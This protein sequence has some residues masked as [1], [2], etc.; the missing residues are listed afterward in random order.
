M[1]DDEEIR[2]EADDDS[3]AEA[4]DRGDSFAG[5][6]GRQRID[7]AQHERIA[8]TEFQQR[9]VDDPLCDRF[10]V[11]GNVRQLGHG[12][13]IAAPPAFMM[14][15]PC[16]RPSDCFSLASPSPCSSPGGPLRC[17]RPF[18]RRSLEVTPSSF[19]WPESPKKRCAMTSTTFTAA[20]R[21]TPS[22]SSRR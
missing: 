18:Q 12:G 4:A 6:L 14:N 10:D 20:I 16:A 17:R 1:D 9:L 2:L 11:Y 22:T 8:E 19:R 7:A 15:T 13:I 21:I 3:L 5:Q